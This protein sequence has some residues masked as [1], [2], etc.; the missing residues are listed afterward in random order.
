MASRPASPHQ[1]ASEPTHGR[2]SGPPPA[3][4]ASSSGRPQQAG[5]GR[6]PAGRNGARR[7]APLAAWPPPPAPLRLGAGTIAWHH[8]LMVFGNPGTMQAPWHHCE[9][10]MG[11]SAILMVPRPA[12]FTSATHTAQ[13][14]RCP[15][16]S[17]PR[18]R[19]HV[20]KKHVQI[21]DRAGDTI[22]LKRGAEVRLRRAWVRCKT[23]AQNIAPSAPFAA[24]PR[25]KL[26]P[27]APW[28]RSSA[29]CNVAGGE[30]ANQRKAARPAAAAASRNTPAAG[31]FGGAARDAAALTRAPAP[32]AILAAGPSAGGRMGRR[33]HLAFLCLVA[34]FLTARCESERYK[35][36]YAPGAGG[37]VGGGLAA[38]AAA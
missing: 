34:A 13:D 32:A 19:R 37:K 12:F 31:R 29:R 3:A 17:A 9:G 7:A 14:S 26:Q 30:P 8:Y 35:V 18:V 33:T 25:T 21:T 16:A 36:S 2:S 5:P 10:A 28:V 1:Q 4:S 6:L 24:P 15:V 27:E 11:P 23:S 38:A 22:V 20:R